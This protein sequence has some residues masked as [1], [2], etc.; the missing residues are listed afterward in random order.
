MLAILL[1]MQLSQAPPQ[2]VGRI[3]TLPWLHV[4]VRAHVYADGRETAVA[5]TVQVS[6]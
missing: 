5:A 1:V 2:P 4:G 6:M 3:L